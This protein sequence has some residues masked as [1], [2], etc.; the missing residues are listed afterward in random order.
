MLWAEFVRE[1]VCRFPDVTISSS[2]LEIK[3][4]ISVMI[5]SFKMF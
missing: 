1:G 2:A 4:I 5:A 3:T